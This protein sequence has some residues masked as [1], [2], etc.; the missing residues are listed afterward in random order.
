MKKLLLCINILLLSSCAV[1]DTHSNVYGSTVSYKPEKEAVLK[2]YMPDLS[3]ADFFVE[4]WNQTYEEYAGMISVAA[5]RAE[6]DIYWTTDSDV[7]KGNEEGYHIK[8]I[9][10]ENP[11]PDIFIR[12]EI[13]NIFYPLYGDGLIFV[14]NKETAKQYGLIVEQLEDFNQLQGV[15][16]GYYFHRNVDSIMPFFLH[17]NDTDD[18]ISMNDLFSDTF[19][20]RYE[21]YRNFYKDINIQDNTL[22]DKIFYEDNGYIS[23]LVTMSE[24]KKTKSYKNM[25]LTFTPMP[26][27]NGK[28]LHTVLDIYG[29]VIKSDSR[30]PKAAFAFLQMLRSDQGI[31]KSIENGFYP[32]LAKE[33]IEKIGIYDTYV[34][35][36]LSAMHDSQLRNFSYIK[37]K[38]SIQ[39]EELM[40]DSDFISLLQNSLYGKDD[41]SLFLQKVKDS[42]LHWI[43]IQ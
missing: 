6:S 26:S 33:D 27:Y 4:L 35:Q 15:K 23:G 39:I 31:K 32:L 28:K 8:N 24:I 20:K 40:K 36:I 5:D 37:E 29:F 41:E 18:A 3:M 17:K 34:K 38:P 42:V 2:I 30:Y 11:C 1:P 22:G 9:N 14:W 12:K 16:Q 19:L 10:V 7:M 43:Y 21:Q 25:N 13:E